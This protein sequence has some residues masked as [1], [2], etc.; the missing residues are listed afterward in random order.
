M[1]HKK[2]L[3]KLLYKYKFTF[4]I[5]GIFSFIINILLLVSPLYMLQIYDRVLS[6]GSHETLYALT[7][8]AFFLLVVFA[9]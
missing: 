3:Q 2:N 6:S 9:F 7:A 5:V 4:I 1:S 8:I